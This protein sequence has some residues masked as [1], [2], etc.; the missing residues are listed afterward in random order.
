MERKTKSLGSSLLIILLIAILLA[1]SAVGIWAWARY[2][3]SIQG[4]ATAQVAKWS[5]KVTGGSNQT[6]EV[7]FPITRTDTNTTVAEGKLAPGTSGQIDIEV[8][9]TG[10][11]TDLV[12]TI[13][14]TMV[15]MPRNLKLY[16]DVEK[17]Q[18]L[19]VVEQQFSK[20]NY[21]TVNDIEQSGVKVETIYWAWPFETGETE[22]DIVRNNEIDTE[23][24]GKEMTMALTVEGKQVNGLPTLADFVKVGDYVNYDANSNGEKTFM[25]SD[26]SEGTGISATISTADSFNS[27]AKS[28]WRVLSVDKVN[29]EV[30]LISADPTAQTVTLTG[31]DGYAN[32]ETVLN[33]IGK[34]YDDGKGAKLDSGRSISIA[35]IEKYSS[36]V[37]EQ[38]KSGAYNYG[39]TASYLFKKSDSSGENLDGSAMVKLTGSDENPAT[40][41][42][43]YY[44][45]VAKNYFS[46][47]IVYNMIFKSSSNVNSNKSTFWLASNCENLTAS[48]ARFIVHNISGGNVSGNSL[49]LSNGLE[50]SVNEHRAVPIISL[51]SNIQTIGQDANGVWQLKID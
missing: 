47:S 32:A 39:D 36:Y 8:D 33:N 16:Y 11:E 43:T 19:A 34:I 44:S 3:S 40:V 24:M 28:Q 12:Y 49:Y 13:S 23:D 9:V 5:F 25:S 27:E 18:E 41:T 46:N 26:C 4:G 15:N 50:H 2:Q 48:F 42:F 22:E 29:G 10:T 6:K 1:S 35:D 31:I 20:G 38:Y 45:Y 7:S 37:K 17:T 30:E 14:G 21:M 51:Q